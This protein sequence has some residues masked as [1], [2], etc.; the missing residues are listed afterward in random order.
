MRSKNKLTRTQIFLM[1]VVILILSV[2]ASLGLVLMWQADGQMQ[3]IDAKI[4]DVRHTL[5]DVTGDLET[6]FPQERDHVERVENLTRLAVE[7]EEL[8]SLGGYEE[9]RSFWQLSEQLQDL[10]YED[11]FAAASREDREALTGAISGLVER[12]I[13]GQDTLP[14]QEELEQ[15]YSV[16]SGIRAQA[17]YDEVPLDSPPPPQMRLEEGISRFQSGS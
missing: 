11:A 2:P 10:K 8:C 4:D 7:T 5:E 3:R 6:L 1:A 12:C 14:T 9:Y 17:G 13:Q 15:I 16:M